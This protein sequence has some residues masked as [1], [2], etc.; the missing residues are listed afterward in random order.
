LYLAGVSGLKE[1]VMDLRRAIAVAVVWAALAF[2]G[3]AAEF[4]VRPAGNDAADGA[5]PATAW[6]TI[7]RGVKDRHPGDTLTIAPGVYDEQVKIDVSGAP[8]RP[9]LV[10]AQRAGFT[11]LKASRRLAGFEP[12]KGM[13]FVSAVRLPQRIYNVAEADTRRMLLRAPGWRDLDEFRNAYHYDDATQTLYV[14]SSDG[15]PASAHSYEA[16]VRHDYGLILAKAKYV[17]VDGIVIQGHYIADR[18]GHGFGLSM[19]G[20]ENCEIRGC[21]F[22]NNAGGATFN[23]GCKDCVVRDCFFAGNNDPLYGEL[24]QLYF[25]AGTVG[26]SAIN[27]VVL[28]APTHG[29]RFYNGAKDCTAVGNIIKNA[30]IGLYYK[31]SGGFRRA[32]KNVVVDCSYYDFHSGENPGPFDCHFNT[33]GPNSVYSE[34][35]LQKSDGTDLVLEKDVDPKFCDPDHLDYRL[36]SDSPYRGKAPQGKDPGAFQFTGNVFFV[37]PAGDDAN[38]GLCAAKPFKT[39]KK[40]CEMAVAGTTVY[41]MPERYRELLLPVHSGEATK[42]VVFRG[43]GMKEGAVA[44]SCALRDRSYIRIENIAFDGPISTAG[45]GDLAF[46]H[47]VSLRARCPAFTVSSPRV[48]ATNCSFGEDCVGTGVKVEENA[49]DFTM[50]SS[51]SADIE[52]AP[53]ALKSAYLE[54][55]CYMQYVRDGRASQVSAGRIDGAGGATTCDLFSISLPYGAHLDGKF[56]GLFEKRGLVFPGSPLIGAGQLGRNIGPWAVQQIDAKETIVDI[57]MRQLT[58]T[59]ASITYWTPSTSSALWR[60]TSGWW[61]GIPRLARVLYGTTPECKDAVSGSFGDVYHRDTL[62]DLK[63]GTKYYFR[64]QLREDP[65]LLSAVQE[66]TTPAAD[67]WKPARRTLYVSPQGNDANDG[68]TRD[69]PFQTLRRASEAALAGDTV[70]VADGIYNETIAP[71][72]TGV[73]G[74][75]ILFKAETLNGAVLD[76]SNFH[77]PSAVLLAQK[78]H[79]VIDGFVMRRF[80]PKNLGRRAGMEYAQVTLWHSRDITV[81]NCVQWGMG[82]YGTAGVAM[83]CNGVVLRNNVIGEFESGWN[84]RE[85]DGRPAGGIELRNNTFYVPMIH[86]MNLAADPFV[87]KNNL[88]FGCEEQKYSGGIIASIPPGPGVDF[89][90]YGFMANDKFKRISRNREGKP[91]DPRWPDGEGLKAWQEEMKVDAHGLELGPDFRFTQAPVINTYHPDFSKFWLPYRQATEAPTIKLFDVPAES[92]LNRAGENGGVVGA[93]STRVE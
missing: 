42:P 88:F 90:A 86:N 6:R 85:W 18:S 73:E 54:Y 24:A 79:V 11:V 76:G 63:P 37:S 56:Q 44:A 3:A 92:P 69:K 9:I 60:S 51:I 72:V 80:A 20:A 12:V 13:R 19:Q 38:D 46:D 33:F 30:R 36:Q 40:A 27:N 93:R 67:A 41:L 71:A 75:P 81:R 59:T 22:L 91:G 48:T 84:A 61:G 58:P 26:S 34:R 70:L 82:N 57:Q 8:D 87:M 83:G 5:S 7:Q 55:N 15:Q 49:E 47:C 68:L 25:S 32:E 39:L 64:I 23:Y 89:N 1:I 50:T 66:F 74:A 28:D 17:H 2:P 62:F 16:T 45:G 65:A 14:H 10:R 4:F 78:G 31:A 21:F 43:L 29:I 53:A 52:I 35:N 77:R